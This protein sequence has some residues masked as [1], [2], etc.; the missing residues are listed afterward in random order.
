LTWT[1][2]PENFERPARPLPA[3]YSSQGFGCRRV[4]RNPNAPTSTRRYRGAVEAKPRYSA[5]PVNYAFHAPLATCYVSRKESGWTGRF[6]RRRHL[7]L[8]VNHCGP[9]ISDR[10]WRCGMR[11]VPSLA[12]RCK[13]AY[14]SQHLQSHMRIWTCGAE[15]SQ[16]QGAPADMLRRS[17]GPRP[18]QL[19]LDDSRNPQPSRRPWTPGLLCRD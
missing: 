1:D 10:P 14:E 18:N 16:I 4:A 13:P 6:G 5:S 9:E 7:P 19:A 17:A 15:R 2:C 11:H 8:A 3:V 12:G